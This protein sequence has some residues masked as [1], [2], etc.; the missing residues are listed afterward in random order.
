MIKIGIIGFGYM[1][2]FHWNKARSFPQARVACVFDTSEE[3]R[4]DAIAEGLT[5]YDRL[6]SF[7]AEDLDLV[8]IA[9]P[10]QWHAPYALAAMKSG[11]NVLCESP[12]P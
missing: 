3:K 7:L 5:A 1:G 9:T 8:I 4:A 6:E 11:K 10:N 2:R 12:P